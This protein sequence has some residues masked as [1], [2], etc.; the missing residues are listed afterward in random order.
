MHLVYCTLHNR[1]FVHLPNPVNAFS[2][3]D[4][5]IL[6]NFILF[7]LRDAHSKEVP[8]HLTILVKLFYFYLETVLQC[9]EIF[10]LAYIHHR[11]ETQE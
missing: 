5:H 3:L 7:L 1:E 6:F 4:K 10:S 2:L 9:I 11:D 8:I